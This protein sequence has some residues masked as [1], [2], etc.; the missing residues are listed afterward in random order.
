MALPTLPH[1]YV[2][3]QSIDGYLLEFPHWL[4]LPFLFFS[5]LFVGV[6]EDENARDM[7]ICGV[8]RTM[9]SYDRAGYLYIYTYKR[10]FTCISIATT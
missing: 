9:V 6:R 5:F 10:I 4:P 8:T 7:G 3:F 1:W 2:N